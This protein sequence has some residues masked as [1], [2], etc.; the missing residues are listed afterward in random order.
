MSV[1]EIAKRIAKNV[2]N[3]GLQAAFPPGCLKCGDPLEGPGSLCN[4]CWPQ[5]TFISEPCCETCGFPFE[6]SPT[7]SLI[8]GNCLRKAPSFSKAR[9]VLKY[10]A[11]CRD[12]ILAFKHADQTRNAPAFAKWMH[13]AAQELIDDCDVICAVPLHPFR[14]HWR[15]FNQSALLT[16]ELALLSKKPPIPDLLFRKRPTRSQGGLNASARR[17]NVQG[18][19]APNPKRLSHLENAR[20]LLIDDV[21]TTGATVEACSKALLNAGAAKI[22]VLTLCR[23]VRTPSLAI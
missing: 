18:A 13:R 14:L 23:V 12:M 7:T 6:Y 22:D 5:M 8:C 1:S 4:I 20:V 2:L 15:R 3:S 11:A 17:R 9:A 21:L 10:D 19:F 16:R